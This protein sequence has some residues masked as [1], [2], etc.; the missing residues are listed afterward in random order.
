MTINNK[1]NNILALTSHGGGGTSITTTKNYSERRNRGLSLTNLTHCISPSEYYNDYYNNDSF[2]EI[3]LQLHASSKVSNP[4]SFSIKSNT[5]FSASIEPEIPNKDTLL[6]SVD[7][8]DE[9]KD[10]SCIVPG[11]ITVLR[12]DYWAESG[13]QEAYTHVYNSSSRTNWVRDNGD[14][15][16]AGGTVYVGVT[17]GKG[18]N[19][20]YRSDGDSYNI[21]I[22]Y[23]SEINTHTPQVK[24]Y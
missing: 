22:F 21:S 10:L 8:T 15:G 12:V 7:D 1:I 16:V 14:E 6:T 3:N 24:D 5:G 13:W 23:S 11:G 4:Y 19:L 2:N 18:Y 20:Y 9:E 17:P